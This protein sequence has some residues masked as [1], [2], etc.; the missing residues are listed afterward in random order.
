MSQ[1]LNTGPL[2]FLDEIPRIRTTNAPTDAKKF[3]ENV[4]AITVS[5]GHL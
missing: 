4:L 5:F 3:E 2:V 1:L